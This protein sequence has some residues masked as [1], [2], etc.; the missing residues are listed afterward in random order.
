[1]AGERRKEEE[2][3]MVLGPLDGAPTPNREILPVLSSLEAIFAQWKKDGKYGMEKEEDSWLYYL[4]GILLTKHGN[5]PRARAAFLRSLNI[6]PWNWGAWLELGY[7]IGTLE[8]VWHYNPLH[9]GKT[10]SRE[11]GTTYIKCS[12]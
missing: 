9:I 10:D 2:M 12:P 5:E 7:L 6:Y 11:C 8:E 1:M 3:E 4:Y